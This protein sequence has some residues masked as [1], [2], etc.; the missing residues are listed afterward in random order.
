VQCKLDHLVVVAPKL[1][2]GAEFVRRVLDVAPEGGG[3]HPTMGT[4]N[5]LLRLGDRAY[6]EVIAIDPAAPRPLRKRWFGLDA[7]PPDAP[8]RLAAWVAWT[9]DIEQVAAA[10]SH[11]GKITPMSRGS[12][13]WRIT[14]RDDGDPPLQ[15]IGPSVIEWPPGVHPADRMPDSGCSL[16][17]LEGYHPDPG[18]VC[19][20]LRTIGFDGPFQVA[21]LASGR[22]PCLIAH[23]QT[24]SGLC[25]LST[26]RA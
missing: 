20:L 11:L 13:N 24:P 7:L 3:A 21:R 16:V 10:A 4:H 9:D 17:R 18:K 23:I 2:V 14:V 6:L 8:P 15:G 26:A 19:I 12:L 1:S 5:C 22:E 25:R